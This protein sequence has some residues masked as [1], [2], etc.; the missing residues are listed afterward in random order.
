MALDD[1]NA[2]GQVITEIQQ[3]LGSIDDLDKMHTFD[4]RVQESIRVRLEELIGA[5]DGKFIADKDAVIAQV[6]PSLK[7]VLDLMKG[8]PP[9]RRQQ[10]VTYLQG[11]VPRLSRRYH[12]FAGSTQSDDQLNEKFGQIA[13]LFGDDATKELRT[14]VDDNTL[15]YVREGKAHTQQ[16]LSRFLSQEQDANTEKLKTLFSS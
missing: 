11:A 7:Q 4:L 5:D 1:V 16:E 3:A 13:Q 14:L 12:T 10:L 6:A 8:M 9:Y 15:Q 2:E